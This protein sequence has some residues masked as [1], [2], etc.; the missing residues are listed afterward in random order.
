LGFNWSRKKL[1][2]VRLTRKLMPGLSSYSLG[3][4]CAT[5]HIP[6]HGRHRAKGDAEATAELLR[7]LI[8]KDTLL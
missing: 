6:I 5:E 3:N 2:T 1:C 7:R 8:L 4:I